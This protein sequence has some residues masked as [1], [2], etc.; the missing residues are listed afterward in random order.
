MINYIVKQI[1]KI[2]SDYLNMNFMI[3]IRQSTRELK[4]TTGVSSEDLI[5]YLK[6]PQKMEV[7]YCAG[8]LDI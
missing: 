8:S 7:R 4:K 2:G 6:D 3:Q 1:G 5:M